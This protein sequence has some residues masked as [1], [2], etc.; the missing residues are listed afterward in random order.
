QG[1]KGVQ[2]PD[3]RHGRGRVAVPHHRAVGVLRAVGRRGGVPALLGDV[4]GRDRGR[5]GRA[6]G[7]NGAAPGPAGTEVLSLRRTS[8]VSPGCSQRRPGSEKA[9]VWYNRCGEVPPIQEGIMV[10]IQF[11]DRDTEKRALAFLLGRFSG[12][13]LKSGLHIVP[14][15]ALEALAHQNIPFTVKGKTTYEQQV[16]AI[17]GT[18]SSPVQ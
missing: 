16:A 7:R 15:A 2:G 10:T 6:D 8:D 9:S 17:R 14:E 3:L 1:T 12:R 13:V 11:P 5:R 18:A 4:P